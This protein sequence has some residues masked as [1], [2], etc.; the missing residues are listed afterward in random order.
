MN[1]NCS[2]LKSKLKVKKCLLGLKEAALKGQ[3]Q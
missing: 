3:K 1:Y 2:T